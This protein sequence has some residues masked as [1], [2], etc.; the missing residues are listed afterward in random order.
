MSLV[1]GEEDSGVVAPFSEREENAA[2]ALKRLQ[3]LRVNKGLGGTFHM[4]GLKGP[5]PHE[6]PK[7]RGFF[8]KER[9]ICRINAAYV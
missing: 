8:L 1:L 9:Y 3:I 6:R 4:R 2:D 5:F 7:A